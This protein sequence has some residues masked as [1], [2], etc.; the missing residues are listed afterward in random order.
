MSGLS[1]DDVRKVALLSRLSF[2]DD[3]A[4]AMAGQLSRILDFVGKLNELDT[5]D[6][7]PTSHALT[8]TNVL[9]ED[10][11]RPGLTLDQVLANAPERESGCFRVPPIIQEM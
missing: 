8:L 11:P 9:R 4:D 6:V 10:R 7:E 5:S 2:A 1:V 3:Q